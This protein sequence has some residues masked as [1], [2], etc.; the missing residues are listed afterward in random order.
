[1]SWLMPRRTYLLRES[2]VTRDGCSSASRPRTAAS[3]SSR[4]PLMLGFDVVG[5]NPLTAADRLQHEA[6]LAVAFGDIGRFGKEQIVRTINWHGRRALEGWPNETAADATLW[7]ST[8]P[9][10]EN[11]G[12]AAYL[13]CKPAGLLNLTSFTYRHSFARRSRLTPQIVGLFAGLERRQ[14]RPDAAGGV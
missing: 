2:S 4:S 10:L 12:E 11:R 9:C 6:P 14:P 8:L 1:M 3:S 5:R 7:R 13:P